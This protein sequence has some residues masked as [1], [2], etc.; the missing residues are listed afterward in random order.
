MSKTNVNQFK[1]N[2]N[3]NDNDNHKRDLL[4][5]FYNKLDTSTQVYKHFLFSCPPV[6]GITHVCKKFQRQ[7]KRKSTITKTTT[8]IKW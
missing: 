1:N 7:V 2:N 3:N 6:Y 4:I 5:T 8:A